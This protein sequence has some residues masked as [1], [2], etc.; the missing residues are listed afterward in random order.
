MAFYLLT[1][2]G[3]PGISQHSCPIK[4]IDIEDNELV[5]VST[6]KETREYDGRYYWTYLRLFWP[7]LVAGGYQ[8]VVREFL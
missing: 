8:F 2:R 5:H 7:F 4:I 1:Y 3:D 6:H